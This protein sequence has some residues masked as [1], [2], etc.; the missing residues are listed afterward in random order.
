MGGDEGY[1][2][3]RQDNRVFRLLDERKRRQFYK[4]SKTVSYSEQEWKKQVEKE[5]WEHKLWIKTPEGRKW[6]KREARAKRR[7]NLLAFGGT[8]MN[9]RIL[10]K[11]MI[12]FEFQWELGPYPDGSIVPCRV[13]F[14]WDEIGQ[15]STKEVGEDCKLIAYGRKP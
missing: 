5:G 1:P 14:N 4:P 13:L 7:Y 6:A 12:G 3:E 11:D 8:E 9:G 2:F 15:I 10:S